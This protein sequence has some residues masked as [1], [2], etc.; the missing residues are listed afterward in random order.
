MCDPHSKLT[1][2]RVSHGFMERLMLRR[3]LDRTP[4][5]RAVITVT[6]R[7]GDEGLKTR[8]LDSVWQ[9][10]S[11]GLANLQ[12][13]FVDSAHADARISIRSGN[14]LG[15]RSERRAAMCRMVSR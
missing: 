5:H 7:D 2:A 14:G 9:R 6:F 1:D 13:A 15:Q 11:P 3:R 4:S 8:V 10:V 12:F